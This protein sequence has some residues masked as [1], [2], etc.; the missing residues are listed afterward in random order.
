M[1]ERRRESLL[2]LRTAAQIKA[3]TTERYEQRKSEMLSGS[4]SGPASYGPTET[5]AYCSRRLLPAHSIVRRVLGEARQLRPDARPVARMLDV[6]SGP[7][8]AIWAA[9]QVWPETLRHVHALDHHQSMVSGL[10][11]TIPPLAAASYPYR[12]PVPVS[13]PD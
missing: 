13:E 6:G 11:I 4:V 2:K 10:P 1:L 12:S 7:G 9:G 3:A 8:T 5:L